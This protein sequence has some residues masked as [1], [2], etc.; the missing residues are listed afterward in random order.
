MSGSRNLQRASPGTSR[1]GR[2]VASAWLTAALLAM[3]FVA[4]DRNPGRPTPVPDVPAAVNLQ[5]TGPGTMAPAV[6]EQFRATAFFSNGSQ[7]DVTSDAVWTTANGSIISVSSTGLATAHDRGETDVQVALSQVFS[8]KRVIVVPPGTFRVAGR[9]LENGVGLTDARIEVTAGST[10]GLSTLSQD[11]RYGL[12][13]VS[14]QME[15]RVTRDGYHPHVQGL[16]VTDHRNLDIPML[17]A[18]PLWD[19]SGSYTVTIAAAPECRNRLPEEA[20]VRTFTAVLSMN[21]TYPRYVGVALSGS[22][23]EKSGFAWAGQIG[24][25]SVTF[26]NRGAYYTS[27]EPLVERLPS[28]RFFFLYSLTAE[29][30]RSPT[31]LDGTVPGNLQVREGGDWLHTTLTSECGPASHR[32][33]LSR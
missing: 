9:V 21:P 11:G 16:N 17:L 25:N 12:Y 2:N 22:N 18:R 3:L 15:L 20:R 30:T 29:V 26:E 7:R 23:L 10:T 32:L 6:A 13:G 28:S 4:C 14:G 8:T 1:L 24:D 5:M 31:G 27:G 19:P 33:T